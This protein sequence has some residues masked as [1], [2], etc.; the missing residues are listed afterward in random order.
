MPPKLKKINNNVFYSG[1]QLLDLTKGTGSEIN[2]EKLKVADRGGILVPIIID[3]KE[4][5][6]KTL[7]GNFYGVTLGQDQLS[8]L[9]VGPYTKKLYYGQ[10]VNFWLANRID[11]NLVIKG[12][13]K[14]T[15]LRRFNKKE[16]TQN[17]NLWGATFDKAFVKEFGNSFIQENKLSRKPKR[18]KKLSFDGKEGATGESGFYASQKYNRGK[19]FL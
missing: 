5:E 19:K 8:K 7:D 9:K 17:Y 11:P 6:A 1:K 16:T 15:V 12:S 3:R 13:K 10:N 4:H 18:F 14:G 2:K